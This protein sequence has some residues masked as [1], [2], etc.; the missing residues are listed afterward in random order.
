METEGSI[1]ENLI[2]LPI[3]DWVIWII[4]AIIILLI[5]I[6]IAKGFFDEMNKK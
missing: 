3:P 1:L 6:F 2:G 4:A 5:V